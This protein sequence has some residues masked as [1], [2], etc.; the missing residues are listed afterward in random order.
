M[1]A[2]EVPTEAVG[3]R[4]CHLRWQHACRVFV[5][6]P[7]AE[8]CTRSIACH[9]QHCSEAVAA[10]AAAVGG[11]ASRKTWS[12]G[13]WSAQELHPRVSKPL[14]VPAPPSTRPLLPCA[15]HGK[16]ARALRVQTQPDTA[17]A[18][19][20]AGNAEQLPKAITAAALPSL[21]HHVHAHGDHCSQAHLLVRARAVE[22][23][24]SAVQQCNIQ[25]CREIEQFRRHRLWGR[26]P[27]YRRRHWFAEQPRSLSQTRALG[28]ARG[29]D[30]TA[31][32]RCLGQRSGERGSWLL[33]LKCAVVR[34]TQWV[35]PGG[36][37][38][39]LR[40]SIG[41]IGPQAVQH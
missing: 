5:L 36:C 10:Q 17:A 6:A 4:L 22:G 28:H 21:L 3:N 27:V 1:T 2:R 25:R 19:G 14:G 39:A 16:T 12:A 23:I 38:W 34:G 15:A 30:P 7:H 41:A 26:S 32:V 18:T 20:S 33:P 40:L 31:G 9:Y 37:R 24:D 35:A 13:F 8:A 29:R 11:P